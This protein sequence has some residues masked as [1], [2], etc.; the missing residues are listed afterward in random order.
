ML[1]P[2]IVDAVRQGGNLISVSLQLRDPRDI[3]I[4]RRFLADEP[5]LKCCP[6]C[7]A[8]NQIGDDDL[9]IRIDSPLANKTGLQIATPTMTCDN[10]G[11][12]VELNM[13]D[14]TAF[15]SVVAFI[16]ALKKRYMELKTEKESKNDEG[17]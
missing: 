14:Y 13:L 9:V 2:K 1:S 7:G 10:C 11:A 5:A 8:E 4:Y 3:A 12:K 17:K 16:S 15:R 6:K